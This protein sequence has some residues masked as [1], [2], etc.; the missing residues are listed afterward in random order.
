M[1]HACN[2]IAMM[3]LVTW[4]D[5]CVQDEHYMLHHKC[6]THTQVICKGALP[7]CLCGVCSIAQAVPDTPHECVSKHAVCVCTKSE[8]FGMCLSVA[9]CRANLPLKAAAT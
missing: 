2:Q 9:Q 6:N 3:V 1:L 7:V 8:A 5:P 4:Q